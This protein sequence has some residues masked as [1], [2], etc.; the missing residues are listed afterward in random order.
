MKIITTLMAILNG[1]VLCHAQSFVNLNF[2]SAVIVT[3]GAPQFEVVAADAI[4]GWIA[5]VGGSSQTY[6]VYNTVSTGAT[7]ISILGTSGVPS[8]IDGAFSI[9]LYG[10]VTDTAASISQTGLVP[11][12][13]N[14]LLFEAQPNPGIGTLV[15]SLGGQDL[16]FVALA[17][18]SN[19]TLYGAEIPTAF[20]GQSEPLI[21]S[22]LTGNNNYWEIDDIQFS[23]ST[24]PE[25][26]GL[27]LIALG[28]LLFGVRRWRNSLCV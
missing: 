22:A 7:S 19:Y 24:V 3:N 15:V 9:E 20:A 16:S 6:I 11:A 27:Y 17:A 8:A 28:T 1:I 13:A 23:S 4:P 14:S 5:D 18:G 25:P 26:S 2:E 21:F 12:S 10:G